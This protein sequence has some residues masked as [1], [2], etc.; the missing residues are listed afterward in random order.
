[1]R[2]LTDLQVFALVATSPD[3]ARHERD[4]AREQCYWLER[5]MGV[6]PEHV[7]ALRSVCARIFGLPA[8]APDDVEPIVMSLAWESEAEPPAFRRPTPRAW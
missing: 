7:A 8:R 4:L 6:F 3:A 5:G 2:T 1:M